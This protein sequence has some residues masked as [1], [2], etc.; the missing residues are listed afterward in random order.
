MEQD[1]ENTKATQTQLFKHLC[2]KGPFVHFHAYETKPVTS[3]VGEI[4][5]LGQ[6]RYHDK[7]VNRFGH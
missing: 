5:H 2:Y 6:T 3:G 1:T 4:F 7:T